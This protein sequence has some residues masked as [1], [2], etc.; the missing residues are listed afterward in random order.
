[1]MGE[2]MFFPGTIYAHQFSVHGWN[3]LERHLLT[4]YDVDLALVWNLM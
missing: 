3:S 1:M 2:K 4:V